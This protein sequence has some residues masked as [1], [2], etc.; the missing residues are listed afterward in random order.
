MR[1]AY[2]LSFAHACDTSRLLAREGHLVFRRGNHILRL[3][4]PSLAT[5]HDP[6]A[7][8]WPTPELGLSI[9]LHDSLYYHPQNGPV[10][11]SNN[12]PNTRLALPRAAVHLAGSPRLYPGSMH[13]IQQHGYASHELRRSYADPVHLAK[14]VVDQERFMA[15]RSR[16]ARHHPHACVDFVASR[17]QRRRPLVAS[18]KQ[19]RDRCHR[20]L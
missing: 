20:S 10:L 2:R 18:L 11:Q 17:T 12:S 3:H 9:E 15:R 8:G 14:R 6:Q 13:L 7:R 5:C 16:A 4:L 1:F 19:K